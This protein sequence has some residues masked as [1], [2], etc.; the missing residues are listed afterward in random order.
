MKYLANKFF[1]LI[2]FYFLKTSNKINLP[3]KI[4]VKKVLVKDLLYEMEILYPQLAKKARAGNFIILRLYDKGERF[5]LT[6]A[7][8]DRERGTITI[9]FQVVGK[10]T[11]LLSLLEVGDEIL[12]IVGP[13]GNPIKIEKYKYPVVI[14]GGG[15]GIAPC[16]PQAKELKDAG[17]KIYSI[18]GARTKELIFWREKM[19]SVSDRL[20]ICT[21]DGTEGIKGVVTE[22][23]KRIISEEPISLVI[24]IGPLIMMKFVA[25]TTSGIEGL[26]RIKTMVSL[27]P[28]MVDGT[29]MCGGCR[30]ATK[31]GEIYFACVDGPDVDGHIVDFDNLIKRSMRFRDYEKKA[32]EYID[33]GCLALRKF[34][35][36]E[37]NN[38]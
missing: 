17:N 20:I 32:M 28:I 5:P 12:D 34:R 7:D 19:S 11:K 23:L 14:V 26:P 30:F 37:I 31:S 16:Y 18:I 29:G 2:I 36:R 15:V 6:I 22:P 27:N 1:L 8:Y 10:S 21:D 4:L 24:A 9:V 35:N 33:E 38:S 13:L 25:L 3:N